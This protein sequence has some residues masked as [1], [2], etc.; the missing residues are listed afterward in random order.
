[1]PRPT[2]GFMTTDIIDY[3][4]P[5]VDVYSDKPWYYIELPP[6]TW[7]PKSLL[8][9]RY[10]V[11]RTMHFN[12]KVR[13]Y[14]AT[15]VRKSDNVVLA[16]LLK[17]GRLSVYQ[18]YQYDGPSGPTVDTPAFIVG[19]LPHD[20]LYQMLR[21]DLLIDAPRIC[22]VYP[23]DYYVEFEKLRLL[24]DQTMREVNIKNGM[25]K[26]RAYYTYKAVRV[27]GEK[28]AMSSY[29]KDYI[30]LWSKS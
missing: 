15:I 3:D 29:V 19:S 12:T 6:N 25:S 10:L 9:R 26:F 22:N 23:P 11:D 7:F 27:F 4:D 16:K 28:N 20:V 1:M 18:G 17:T 30:K 14:E 5:E 21:E 24:A 2:G 13:G 8:Y